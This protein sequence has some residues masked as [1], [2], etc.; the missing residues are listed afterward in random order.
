[1]TMSVTE[2]DRLDGVV[3]LLDPAR[4]AVRTS[5]PGSKAA[6]ALFEEV[7]ST[8]SAR[9][10]LRAPLFALPAP[11][12]RRGRTVALLVAALLVLGATGGYA[13]SVW[14]SPEQQLSA[15]DR[16]AQAIPLPPG[17]SF[18]AVRAGIERDPGQ[19]EEA[20]L[21]GALAFAATCQWYGYWLDGF[22]RGDEAQVSTALRTID[23]I[24]SW[25]Q[26][27]ASGSGPGSTVEVLRQ[28]ARSADS[29]SAEPVR[30]FLTANCDAEPWY[31]AANR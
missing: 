29:G 31:D 6:R 17:G 13:A 22:N 15:V 25:P 2:R 7:V 26:L 20:G 1:M 14:L 19:M 21:N 28:L 8:S 24:P 12:R 18:D 30:G 5:E 11:G 4:N 3:R 27:A 23:A 16:L 10:E 9:T